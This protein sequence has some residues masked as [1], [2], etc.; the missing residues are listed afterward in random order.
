MKMDTKGLTALLEDELHM[1]SSEDS[2]SGSSAGSTPAATPTSTEQQ[3]HGDVAEQKHSTKVWDEWTATRIGRSQWACI[4]GTSSCDSHCF[5]WAG[6]ILLHNITHYT[7]YVHLL[8]PAATAVAV[9]ICSL[10]ILSS[11]YVTL[12]IN[13]SPAPIQYE[14]TALSVAHT[15]LFNN[16]HSGQ[17]IHY[18]YYY[19][20]QSLRVIDESLMLVLERMYAVELDQ[21]DW[22]ILVLVIAWSFQPHLSWTY[23][24]WHWSWWAWWVY[25]QFILRLN[26]CVIGMSV[27][28]HAWWEY[29][30]L[31]MSWTSDHR[32]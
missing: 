7:Q 29:D 28:K 32:Q 14:K 16:F 27:T 22:L 10:I 12:I 15:W 17:I 18:S 21:P 26:L 11:I 20:L 1:F 3:Q 6:C 30:K 5:A 13:E 4:H 9:S 31:L 2:S 23:K 8:T 19:S 25:G 24:L